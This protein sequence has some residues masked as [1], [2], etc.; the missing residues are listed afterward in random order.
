MLVLH[1]VVAVFLVGTAGGF[2][3]EVLNLYE[4]RRTDPADLPKYLKSKFYWGMN[5]IMA[6]IGGGLAL[7]YGFKESNAM[8]VV[9]IGI[10]APL[11]IK[12]LAGNVPPITKPR[13][14]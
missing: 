13:V 6:A 9:N 3:G 14:D 7:L 2:L 10:S 11:I 4:L 1:G 5:I 8:L 12:S